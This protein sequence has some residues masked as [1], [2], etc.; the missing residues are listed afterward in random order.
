MFK[1]KGIIEIDDDK[2]DIKNKSYVDG[3]WCVEDQHIIEHV[4]NYGLFSQ[5]VMRVLTRTTKRMWCYKL[6]S[7]LCSLSPDATVS[8]Q[9]GTVIRTQVSQP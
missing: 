8:K 3:D 7:S 1:V 4:K 9:S 2:E 6:P 5:S